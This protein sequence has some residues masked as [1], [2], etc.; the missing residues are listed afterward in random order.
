MATHHFPPGGAAAAFKLTAA[1]ADGVI[2]AMI[3]L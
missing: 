1:R 2:K 3:T